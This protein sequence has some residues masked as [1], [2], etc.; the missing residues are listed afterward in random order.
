M[1]SSPA[2]SDPP[3]SI[4]PVIAWR[5]WRL[6]GSDGVP[7]LMSITRPTAWP[8][9]EPMLAEC[10]THHDGPVR[11]GCRCGLYAAGSPERLARAGATRWHPGVVG[12]VALWGSVV[13]HAQGARAQF[14]YPQR[15]RLVCG[16]CLSKGR[17]AV[18]PSVVIDMYGQLV[19]V[20]ER[21]RG[22]VRGI[23]RPAAMVQADLLSAYGVDLL[24]L[25]PLDPGLRYWPRVSDPLGW[26]RLLTR[27]TIRTAVV[28]SCLWV[29][30]AFLSLGSVT[31]SAVGHVFGGTTVGPTAAPL[32]SPTPAP[33]MPA[34]RVP[35]R[36]FIEPARTFPPAASGDVLIRR[37]AGLSR[38]APPDRAKVR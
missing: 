3:L 10:F 32:V 19:P 27:G 13:E 30:L 35:V 37:P 26:L 28:V 38:R 5:A 21:H 23:E 24:P 16:L 6:E 7:T 22:R 1:V 8:H 36:S 17:G 31:S 4:E 12:E 2:R 25:E 9:R 33:G 11:S 14:G 20:C 15:V 18:D 34:H 29:A